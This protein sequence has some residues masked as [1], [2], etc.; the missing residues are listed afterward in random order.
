MQQGTESKK[1]QNT[2]Q[3]IAKVGVWTRIPR[4]RK[5][6]GKRFCSREGFLPVPPTADTKKGGIKGLEK[7]R[8]K[9]M[10][11]PQIRTALRRGRLGRLTEEVT[12][13]DVS[14]KPV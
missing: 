5:G 8:K 7:S 12:G 1:R 3:E 4:T 9:R 10:E 13:A 11:R 2:S 6:E 14:G